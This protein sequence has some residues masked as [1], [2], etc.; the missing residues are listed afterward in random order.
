MDHSALSIIF[1]CFRFLF[2]EPTSITSNRLCRDLLHIADDYSY[3]I[4]M[5]LMIFV[6]FLTMTANNP[7]L[8]FMMFY[9]FNITA[10]HEIITSVS[11]DGASLNDMVCYS[12]QYIYAYLKHVSMHTT[13]IHAVRTV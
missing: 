6:P 2:L 8:K 7:N 4:R 11:G 12:K 9:D 13:K 3:W 5:A 10:Q 1:K